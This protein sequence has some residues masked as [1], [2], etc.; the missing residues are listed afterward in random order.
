[1]S[2]GT[3]DSTPGRSTG[4]RFALAGAIAA[5][6]V[7]L[8][9]A[10]KRW[11][12]SSFTAEPVEVLGTFLRFRFVENPGA[13]FSLFPSGGSFLGVAAILIVAGVIWL[14]RTPRPTWE[15]VGFGL[16]IGGALGNLIDRIA[17][18]DGLLDG[19]VIDWI[20]LWFIPTFNL[21]DTAITFAVLVFLVGSWAIRE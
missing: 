11:A 17:R 8:D 14:L 9:L 5:A 12:S 13:A 4:G 19:P 2:A 7:V 21:A 16:V 6:V 1:M 15:V 18:G 20:D 3:G 10:T